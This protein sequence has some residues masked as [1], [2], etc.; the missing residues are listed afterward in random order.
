MSSHSTTLQKAC[1]DLV[2]N[3]VPEEGNGPWGGCHWVRATGYCCL[4]NVLGPVQSTVNFDA[5]LPLV[6][7]WRKQ[8]HFR[9]GLRL[10]ER[11]GL[12]FKYTH[13]GWRKP[14]KN[15]VLVGICH[16]GCSQKVDCLVGYKRRR[17]LRQVVL[18]GWPWL[19]PISGG[20]EGLCRTH[21]D[22]SA[23]GP[24]PGVGRCTDLVRKGPQEFHALPNAW[25]TSGGLRALPIG[26]PLGGR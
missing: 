12:T 16:D 21:N 8:M 19:W 18:G 9:Q 23:L 22:V 15:E 7:G 26:E 24:G 5:M 6:E 25:D 14:T 11:S 20:I 1:F 2:C 10:H 4:H 3:V 17:A 13:P